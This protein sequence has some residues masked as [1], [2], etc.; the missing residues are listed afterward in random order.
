M[1]NK[2]L[3]KLLVFI[4]LIGSVLP[5]GYMVFSATSGYIAM[6]NPD[7]E[8][9]VDIEA[10][11][12]PPVSEEVGTKKERNAEELPP[13]KKVPVVTKEMKD[14]IAALDSADS[15]R[16][17]RNHEEAL[18]ALKVTEKLQT[19]LEEM[20]TKEHS[21][22]EVLTAYEFLYDE[23]GTIDE[24]EELLNKKKSGKDWAS[25]FKEYNKNKKEFVPGNFKPGELE[26]LMESGNLSPDDIMTADRISQK[27][28][29]TF[30]ELVNK[31]MMGW[32]WQDINSELGV[33]NTSGSFPI[34]AVDK[35]EMEA[36]LKTT[37][38]TRQQVVK[39]FKLAAKVGKPQ[40]EIVGKLKDGS[41]EEDILALYYSEKYG[42]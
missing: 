22:P 7:N 27:G 23:F 5:M 12:K 10:I 29:G 8:S 30:S 35:E 24:L 3:A 40:A 2:K 1:K 13:V 6:L 39:G 33:I 41:R 26:N 14:K 25:I 38:L 19:K 15:A 32:D 9:N 31:R 16:N 34:V 37:G 42:K 21:V 4:L 17:I 18:K 36:Y 28:L 20:Y 11:E